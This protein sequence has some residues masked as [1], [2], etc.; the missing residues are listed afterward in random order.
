MIASNPAESTIQASEDSPIYF[1]KDESSHG[2]SSSSRRPPASV[3]AALLGSLHGD[4]AT[5]SSTSMI[6]CPAGLLMDSCMVLQH[7]AS[8][9]VRELA[10][11]LYAGANQYDPAPWIDLQPKRCR[12]SRGPSPWHTVHRPVAT[13]IRDAAGVL[14][15]YVV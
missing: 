2:T 10:T 8:L 5:G 1:Y 14:P 9:R 3:G 15:G 6:S 11:T 13:L 12:S 4:D 7:T